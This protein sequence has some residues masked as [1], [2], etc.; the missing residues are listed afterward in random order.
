MATRTESAVCC[1]AADQ[2]RDNPPA[3]RGFFATLIALLLAV[4]VYV[5]A[6]AAGVLA[7]LNPLRQKGQASRWLPLVTLEAIPDD[8]TPRKFAVVADHSDAWTHYPKE[9]IGSVFLRRHGLN[10][11][12][13]LQVV[14]PHAGCFVVH[15]AQK[16]GFFCPC[17]SA[18]FDL[19]GKR[20]GA[21][22]P[23]PRDMDSLEVELKGNTVWV[24]YQ[25]FRNGI[26]Q[27]IAEA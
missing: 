6:A 19:D 21:V 2:T 17:H 13:A 10:Q 22:C 18:S 8:G 16:N 27:K 11:V 25:K 14:C 24:N 1:C 23:S 26:P 15:D 20:I 3:R 4:G 9:P 7:L 12:Q 5:P